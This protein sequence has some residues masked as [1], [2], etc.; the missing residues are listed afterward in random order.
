MKKIVG[1]ATAAIM[2]APVFTQA[3]ADTVDGGVVSKVEDNYS[4]TLNIVDETSGV[5]TETTVIVDSEQ[6]V[7]EYL[8]TKGF[9]T[10]T[11][12]SETDVHALPLNNTTLEVSY[13]KTGLTKE[14]K[15][16]NF[17][18]L[19]QNSN[20]LYIGETKVQQ[21]GVNGEAEVI[22]DGDIS[23]TV[24]TKKPVPKIILVGTKERPAPQQEQ[25]PSLPTNNE[26]AQLS[27][28]SSN[29]SNTSRN[30]TRASTESRNSSSNRANRQSTRSNSTRNNVNDVT[31]GEGLTNYSPLAADKSD[32]T[33]KSISSGN[34]NNI[35]QTALAQVGKPYVWGAAGPDA[36]DCSGFIYHVLNT[37]GYK[38][39]RLT[40]RDYGARSTPINNVNDLVP[41][42][43]LWTEAHIAMYVGKDE[44]G[45]RKIV[46]AANS[47][48][49]V[50][51][52]NA[53]WFLNNGYQMG[54]LI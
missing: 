31:V 48:V 20:E 14:T 52:A 41:G 3:T 15:T 27:E 53:D 54:R 12:I 39:P 13:A 22:I 18:T 37:S 45:V 26:P 17:R 16:L 25:S 2:L 8:E 42:D 40:A 11:V 7:A 34:Q 43:I 30:E 9:N 24:I 6:T 28:R 32:K 21:E 51:T 33:I 44:N 4:Y 36:M 29:G 47:R 46:H 19:E 1:L 50:V 49:G 38:V 35:T 5:P 23:N 10:E